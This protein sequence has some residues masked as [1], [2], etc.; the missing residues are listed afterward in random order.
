MDTDRTL[1]IV[2]ALALA[3]GSGC[4]ALQGS[5]TP[6]GPGTP[7]G[8]AIAN[9][10]VAAMEGV[11]AYTYDSTATATR[12]GSTSTIN[13]TGVVDLA[14]RRLQMRQVSGS[15]SLSQ[16]VV[17]D[18]IYSNG[19]GDWRSGPLRGD[20]FW[21][22][23]LPLAS[24]RA[25]LERANVTDVRDATVEDT[26]VYVLSLNL[27]DQQLREYHDR[28]LP[29]RFPSAVTFSDTSYR[30]Y[31]TQDDHRLVRVTSETTA[32]LDGQQLDATTAMD[33]GGYDENV[34]VDLPEELADAG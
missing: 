11:D 2:L 34:S 22:E 5:G 8:A 28:R 13:V 12:N 14:D 3:L 32:S 27:T 33:V 1:A 15:Q 6:D 16:F 10:T 21:T 7:D 18:T 19:S 30:V 31:V 9:E 4:A 23:S 25:L 26:A 29:L 20:N 24:Q 17:N